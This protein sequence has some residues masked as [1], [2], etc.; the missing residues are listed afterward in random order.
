MT[1]QKA[2]HAAPL[3]SRRKTE[4]WCA[5]Q[6]ISILDPHKEARGQEW[7]LY[8]RDRR[9]KPNRLEAK[10]VNLNVSNLSYPLSDVLS[11]IDLKANL[12]GKLLSGS[13]S[14]TGTLNAVRQS[15]NVGLDG[16][17]LA[18]VDLPASGRRRASAK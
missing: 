17:K 14:V 12:T 15:F 3:G 2:S 5:V 6:E 7:D 11:D 8:F 18:L 16:E 1:S 9:L 10:Q 4:R 13:I